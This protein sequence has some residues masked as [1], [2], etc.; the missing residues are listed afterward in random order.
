MVAI[1][2]HIQSQFLIMN[3]SAS[4]NNNT[5][6]IVQNQ[7]ITMQTPSIPSA[8]DHQSNS[9]TGLKQQQPHRISADNPNGSNPSN[10]ARYGRNRRR[11]NTGG[12]NNFNNTRPEVNLLPGP[13]GELTQSVHEPKSRPTRF[14][15][16]NKNFG[17]QSQ[18][19]TGG[20]NAANGLKHRQRQKTKQLIEGLSGF[21]ELEIGIQDE[22]I[23]SNN[24]HNTNN[25]SSRHNLSVKKMNLTQLVNRS[26]NSDSR[27][28]SNSRNYSNN[29]R[30]QNHRRNNKT[31]S[32]RDPGV[33]H[34]FSKQQFL[35]ANCQFVVLDG[36]DYSVH[37][38]DPDW[39][40]D[41]DCIE[42]IK[43]KQC[44]TT[45]TTCPI[46]LESPV[47]AKITKCGHIYCWTCML[48]YLSLSDEKCRQCP[49][50]F[51]FVYKNDL[52]SVVSHSYISHSV[53]VEIDMRLMVRKKGC[54]TAEPYIISD[55]YNQYCYNLNN[56]I[57]MEGQD[58]MENSDYWSQQ[59]LFI[60]DSKTVISKIVDREQRELT[61]KLNCDHDEPE[62]C[63]I[64]QALEMLGER[65]TRLEQLSSRSNT[66]KQQQQQNLN[67]QNRNSTCHNQQTHLDLSSSYLFY[68]SCDGQ[69]IYLNPFSTKIMCQEYKSLENCPL[70]IRAK[71]LQMD[72]ISMSEAWRK[73]F[74]Y[75]SHL[76]LTCEFRL[77]EID[78][79]KSNLI[80]K[81]TFKMFEEQ[82]KSREM[83]RERARREER[84]REKII[85]VEQ[86]RKIYGIGPSLKININNPD[87]FPSVSDERY[88]GLSLA[89]TD[90][91]APDGT[92]DMSSDDENEQLIG[93]LED[94]EAALQDA[95]TISQEDNSTISTGIALSFQEIQLQEA[96]AA[97]AAAANSAKSP[98]VNSS[99]GQHGNKHQQAPSTHS[100]SNGPAQSS[101]F[102]K[103]LTD[104]KASKKEWTVKA[105]ARQPVAPAA[106]M[107]S[108]SLDSTTSNQMHQLS[109]LS[110]F[111]YPNLGDDLLDQDDVH[112][113]ELRAP[114]NFT[115][116]D[117]IDNNI[118]VS[119]KKSRAKHKGG[120]SGNVNKK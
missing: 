6:P 61:T 9:A 118:I 41:W 81:Q 47:A 29:N 32:Y 66:Y 48:H 101:S 40:V 63:F 2:I 16:N 109:S 93:A 5:N 30:S 1:Q 85:K 102:A 64:E 31:S 65:R 71:V 72:W 86:D 107:T 13:S 33:V 113:E 43:F 14:N 44:A 59:N 74:R 73:R 92:F 28:F 103:L 69:H 36:H 95:I 3:S 67:Y 53:D 94:Q 108:N 34:K 120:S 89:T 4:N 15:S 24:Y 88:L 51:E 105:S 75:L 37:R 27:D 22:A 11:P 50:C 114:G 87:Q 79:E 12:Q 104:A 38:V 58:L 84:K 112:Q 116:S 55:D 56:P 7:S 82:I 76:P 90:H 54:V 70:E 45:E 49:I 91:I 106:A 110:R 19:S 10:R 25:H 119:T 117:F 96:A 99:W 97:A 60:V 62:V 35:Q 26:A 8:T 57:G 23:P 18:A 100:K 77:I 17:S 83:A 52:R 42:E 68:Q 46:C 80:S 98:P 78:F 111:N 39:P 115:I 20:S 21:A